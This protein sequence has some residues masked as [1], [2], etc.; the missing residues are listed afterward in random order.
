MSD[1]CL[2]PRLRSASQE[3]GEDVAIIGIR[4]LV[5]KT[6]DI[7]GRVEA[8]N[9]PFLITRH[10]KPVAALVP[11]DPSQAE[12]Y[13]LASS[14]DFLQLRNEVA[15]EPQA[16]TPLEEVG[17]E[18][19][20][21]PESPEQ[22]LPT[23]VYSMFTKDVVDQLETEATNGFADL[24]DS[25]MKTAQESGLIRQPSDAERVRE[26]NYT[27]FSSVFNKAV[28]DSVAVNV[29]DVAAGV[30]ATRHK[31]T[32]GKTLADD[33]LEKTT[34][35]V[36]AANEK[37]FALGEETGVVESIGAYT[38]LIRWNIDTVKGAH[39]KFVPSVKRAYGGELWT[40]GYPV[41]PD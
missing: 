32:F 16:V 28:A 29:E 18:L 39:Y 21:E 38:M 12:R 20:I 4:D 8:G 5:R 10:G 17:A 11:V 24:S 40:G 26:L 25:V 6:T 15:A 9:E 30:E 36:N 1:K 3:G 33:A 2:T 7:L 35:Y 31:E 34:A 27:L 19:G 14:P 23:F 41:V 37:F 13:V 22:L